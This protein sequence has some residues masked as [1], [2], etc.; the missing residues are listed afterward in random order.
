MLFGGHQWGR[1]ASKKELEE[2]E[3][4]FSIRARTTSWMSDIIY[5]SALR[6]SRSG[7]LPCAKAVSIYPLNMSALGPLGPVPSPLP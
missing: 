3:M 5:T 1:V 7:Q 2:T 4:L 6:D